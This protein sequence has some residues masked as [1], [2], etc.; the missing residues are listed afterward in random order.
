VF[1]FPGR[2]LTNGG[3]TYAANLVVKKKAMQHIM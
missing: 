1:E 2:S 3:N